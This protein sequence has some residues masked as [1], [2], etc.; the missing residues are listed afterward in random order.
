MRT[1]LSEYDRWE[2]RY[3]MPDYTVGRQSN[4][5]LAQCK[6]LLP[7]SGNALAVADGED[8]NGVW[9]AKQGRDVVSLDF[10]PS[11]QAKAEGL[12]RGHGL[13]MTIEPGDVHNWNYPDAAFDIVYEIFTRFSTPDRR[14]RKWAGNEED[15]Q[16]ERA[17][18]PYRLYA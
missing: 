10:S 11:A 1:F 5:L 7:K 14:A 4:Y 12:A 18:Y 8:C 9:L 16:A 13:M 15:T 3:R 17:S 6:H 2:A